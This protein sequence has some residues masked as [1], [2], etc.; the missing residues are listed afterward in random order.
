MVTL[1]MGY[2]AI[3]TVIAV[4]YAIARAHYDAGLHVAMVAFSGF[5]HVI[6]VTAVRQPGALFPEAAPM[7]IEPEAAPRVA[8]S[9][10]VRRGHIE[11]L[12]A[13]MERE[14]LYRHSE[15]KLGDLAG[16]LAISTHH[17]SAILNGDL[18]T[19]FY[20]FVNGYRVREVQ[21][22]LGGPDAA[23]HTL[24]AIALDAG[25]NSKTSFNRIFKK[26]AGCT[27]SAWMREARLDRSA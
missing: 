9:A 22:R 20:D 2:V 5:T 11:T 18:E 14:R 26:H 21:D 25:F 1:F 13:L 27:P 7:A 8:L 19:T 24:L 3:D 16:R 17:L 6:A 12:R 23:R 15:L 4:G 10:D